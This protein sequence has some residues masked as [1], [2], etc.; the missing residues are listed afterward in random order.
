MW[1]KLN[2]FTEIF[3]LGYVGLPLAI[4]FAAKYETITPQKLLDVSR[5]DSLGRQAK[6]SLENGIKAT[7]N[8]FIRE[9]VW[10]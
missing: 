1:V 6:I 9:G 10:S 4:H 3:G 7:Y 2:R 8:W 5:L